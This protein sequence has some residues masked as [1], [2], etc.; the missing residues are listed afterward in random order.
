MTSA[1]AQEYKVVSDFRL[2]T[3]IEIEKSIAERWKL[4]FETKMKREKDASILDE[5]DFD[6]YANFKLFK[7]LNLGTG[8]RIALNQKS[9]KS[10]ALKH[11]ILADINLDER[12]KRFKIEYRLRYQN[13]DDDFFLYDEGKAPAN[14]LRNRVLCRY[15]IRK[16]KLT[17]YFFSEL[18]GRLESYY[19]FAL[20]LKT[21]A[22][23][24]YNLKQFGLI[25]LY[26][27]IDREIGTHVPYTYYTLGVGYSYDF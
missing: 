6:L 7:F 20:K 14:I 13:I 21:G 22:G 9:D 11:R 12:F 5:I 24:R 19:P 27:R 8:Y 25:K 23:I 26:Y 18:Y 2:N 17:P 1:S 15:D 3:E 4:S 10:F 16:S